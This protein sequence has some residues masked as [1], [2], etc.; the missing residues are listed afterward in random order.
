MKAKKKP[1]EKKTPS[2]YGVEIIPQTEILEV[3]FLQ[4]F[5]SRLELR[6]SMFLATW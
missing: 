4:T 3:N 6:I 5:L 2:D 1:L